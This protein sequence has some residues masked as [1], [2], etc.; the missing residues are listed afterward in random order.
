M[1]LS[2]LAICSSELETPKLKCHQSITQLNYVHQTV[3]IIRCEQKTVSLFHVS[4]ST[5]R[6][7]AAKTVLERTRKLFVK[8]RVQVVIVG[9]Q[10][11]LQM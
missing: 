8:Y 2:L 3:Q 4:P 1:H 11:P 5:K 10:I 7:V 9:T 6:E